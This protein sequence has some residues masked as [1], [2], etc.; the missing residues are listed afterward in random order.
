MD[1]RHTGSVHGLPIFQESRFGGLQTLREGRDVEGK[2]HRCFSEVR[3]SLDS[4]AEGSEKEESELNERVEVMEYSLRKR[5]LL[6]VAEEVALEDRRS[7][8]DLSGSIENDGLHLVRHGE[9]VRRK[10][11]DRSESIES[12]LFELFLEGSED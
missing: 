5:E 11:Y 6:Q 10:E 8:Q 4:T 9:P 12:A 3:A 7:R 2:S 1:R